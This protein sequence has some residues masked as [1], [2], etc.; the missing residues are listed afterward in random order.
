M[1]LSFV[2]GVG[3]GVLCS[4]VA[5]LLVW[6]WSGMGQREPSIE[7]HHERLQMWTKEGHL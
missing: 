3:V 2:L 7:L 4:Y 5:L 6:G 1:R